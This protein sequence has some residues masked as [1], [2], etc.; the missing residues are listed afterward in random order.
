MTGALTQTDDQQRAGKPRS[1]SPTRSERVYLNNA[2]AALMSAETV[3]AIQSHLQL[4]RT[5]GSY[6]ADQHAEPELRRGY[7]VAAELLGCSAG[8]VAFTESSSR[9]WQAILSAMVF[10]PGDVILTGETEWGGNCTALVLAAERA[11]ASIRVVPSLDDGTVDVGVLAAA[12]DVRVRLI[13]LTWVPSGVGI[14]N[15]VAAVGALARAAGV[16][17]LLD[18][19]QAVGQLPT[20]VEAIGCDALA[21]PGRKWLRG[22]RGTG[23]LYVRAAFADR[24]LPSTSDYLSVTDTPE[25]RNWREGARK[26]ETAERSTALRLGFITAIE[27]QLSC[28]IEKIQK[29][30][31]ELAEYGRLR[32]AR[33][34]GLKLLESS[35]PQSGILTLVADKVPATELDRKLAR[36]GVDVAAIG[37]AF[38]PIAFDKAGLN[39]VLRV[40]PH[41]YNTRADIDRLVAVLGRELATGVA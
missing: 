21:A 25:G 1:G 15:P 22:P 17:F 2:A 13:A 16:P 29:T 18:A 26:F 41:E 9:G 12:I 10:A 35:D 34:P 36:D 27:Q 33:L 23:L 38:T 8:E 31:G 39:D 11:G 28:G 24:L 3:T 14:V 19:A 40:S 30:I 20:D 32:L 6:R 37:R 7:Q 5:E 4:E